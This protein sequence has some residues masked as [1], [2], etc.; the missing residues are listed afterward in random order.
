[1]NDLICKYEICCKNPQ[2]FYFFPPIVKMNTTL[3]DFWLRISFFYAS[4]TSDLDDFTVYD[5]D[6]IINWRWRKSML[7]KGGSIKRLYCELR[8]LQKIKG[9]RTGIDIISYS[10]NNLQTN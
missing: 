7:L 1:M 10:F 9:I 4:I 6:C 5:I 2:R 3:P 8:L